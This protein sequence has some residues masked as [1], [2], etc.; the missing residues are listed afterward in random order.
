MGVKGL[1]ADIEL[2]AVVIVL[3]SNRVFERVDNLSIDKTNLNKK[4]N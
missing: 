1:K 2:S 4:Q 3:T